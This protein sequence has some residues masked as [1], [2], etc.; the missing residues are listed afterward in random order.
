MKKKNILTRCES[1][2]E[3]ARMLQ[4]LA[5]SRAIR[6]W[7]GPR[8][9]MSVESCSSSMAGDMEDSVLGVFEEDERHGGDQV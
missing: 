9:T 3:R 4:R 8:D 5:G 1:E 2:R 7:T 6:H